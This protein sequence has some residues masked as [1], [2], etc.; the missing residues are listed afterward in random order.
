MPSRK[1]MIIASLVAVVGCESAEATLGLDE[2][3]RVQDAWFL[4][5]DLPEADDVGVVTSI[6]VANSILIRGQRGRILTGRVAENAYALGLRL[7][8]QGSGWWVLPVQ[9]LNPMYPGERDFRVVYDVADRVALGSTALSLAAVGE[10]G[11]RGPVYRLAVCTNDAL[12]PRGLNACDP[13][14]PPPAAVISLE[15]DHNV[16]LDLVVRTPEGTDVSWKQPITAPP[17][18]EG[19]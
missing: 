4:P 5:E 12:V 17:G 19:V 2:P 9:D 6:D 10:G 15:W 7:E 18:T 1:S 13:T 3:I 8:G 11:E 14:L 16:D